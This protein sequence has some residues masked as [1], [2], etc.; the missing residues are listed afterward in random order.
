MSHLR[1]EYERG[2]LRE[3]LHREPMIGVKL[4]SGSLDALRDYMRA[5]E[6]GFNTDMKFTLHTPVV[7]KLNLTIK[8]PTY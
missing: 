5:F 1:N 4:I 7:N 6:G 8:L 3:P 2:S